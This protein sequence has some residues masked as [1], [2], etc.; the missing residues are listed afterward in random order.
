MRVSELSLVIVSV[1]V[2]VNVRDQI[3]IICWSSQSLLTAHSAPSFRIR[4]GVIDRTMAANPFK[5]GPPPSPPSTPVRPAEKA[6]HGKN[7]LDNL[8]AEKLHKAG[9]LTRARLIITMMQVIQRLEIELEEKWEERKKIGDEKKTLEHKANVMSFQL[10]QCSDVIDAKQER[11]A[12]MKRALDSAE[13]D[14][15]DLGKKQ[16]RTTA[17]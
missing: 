14:F 13:R 5:R 3:V 2:I 4:R 8:D 15:E 17:V 9:R 10:M 11:L 1:I 12:T 6:R 16:P 7:L